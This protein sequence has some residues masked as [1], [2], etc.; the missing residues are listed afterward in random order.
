MDSGRKTYG[1][2]MK[3]DVCGKL[4]QTEDLVKRGKSAKEERTASKG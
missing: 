3:P 1:T 4:C 2:S